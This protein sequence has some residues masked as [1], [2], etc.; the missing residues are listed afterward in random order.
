MAAQCT[1]S[2]KKPCL[3]PLCPHL[4]LPHL[5]H[6]RVQHGG[7]PLGVGQERLGEGEA[8]AVGGAAGKREC[9]LALHGGED[10]RDNRVV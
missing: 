6:Q 4:H 10:G 9:D 3:Q 2:A 1:A 8:A 5:R 7:M